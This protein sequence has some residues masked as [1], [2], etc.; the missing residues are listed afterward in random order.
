[1]KY[2]L[3]KKYP[4]LPSD[5]E[6]G[7][8]VGTGDRYI[9]T[10][11][12][13]FDCKYKDYY[14][15]YAEVVYNPEYWEDM[16]LSTNTSHVVDLKC[17]EYLTKENPTFEKRMQDLEYMVGKIEKTIE[18]IDKKIHNDVLEKQEPKGKIVFDWLIG[19]SGTDYE[20]ELS[21]S[22]FNEVIEIYTIG[23]N[24]YL[25]AAYIKTWEYPRIYIGHYE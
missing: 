18:L 7:M 12:S 23:V 24:K 25:F 13:P 8:V 5:W 3:I 2:K 20:T 10:A 21:P 1:M 15:P 16:S 6:V 17:N 14:V 4:S 19:D 11:F 9:P 22:R